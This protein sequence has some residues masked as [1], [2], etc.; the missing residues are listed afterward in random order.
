M[1]AKATSVS[2]CYT[3]TLYTQ[4]FKR[5]FLFFIINNFIQQGCNEVIKRNRKE[6]YNVTKYLSFEINAIQTVF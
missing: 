2:L 5:L 1:K 6:M 3:G 4:S